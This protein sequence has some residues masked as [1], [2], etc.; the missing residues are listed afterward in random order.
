M[1]ILAVA[2]FVVSV[3]DVAVTVTVAPVGTA[4]GAVKSVAM[5]ARDLATLKAPPLAL[6]Q[7]AVQVTPALAESLV[8]KAVKAAPV[9]TCREVGPG[10]SVTA[11]IG[12]I[13][14]VADADFVL[15][16]REVAVT[17]TVLPV[18]SVAGAV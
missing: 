9:E 18:G 7:V 1:V 4:D 15:S 8:T 2:D 5:P 12:T 10:P 14:M 16:V 11:M 3:T 6:P 17:V 13:V